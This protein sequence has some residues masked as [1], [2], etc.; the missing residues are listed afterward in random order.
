[1]ETLVR[2]VTP[3]VGTAFSNPGIYA[4]LPVAKPSP[5]LEAPPD[6]DMRLTALPPQNSG[7]CGSSSTVQAV[8]EAKPA[9]RNGACQ[10]PRPVLLRAVGGEGLKISPSATANCKLTAALAKWAQTVVAPAA[11][12]HL[13]VSVVSVRN[14]ASYACRRRNNSKRGRISEHAFA[15]ALDV[16]TFNLANGGKV[17]VSKDWRGGGAKQAFLREVHKKSCGVFKTVLGPNSDRFHASHF[18]LDLAKRR[19]T[20]CR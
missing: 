14:M 4:P 13:G 10:V 3:V 18:H 7:I 2:S 5:P 8:Y 1:M 15:N 6:P 11:R 20:Y 19:S 12:R 9:I 16:G 17:T